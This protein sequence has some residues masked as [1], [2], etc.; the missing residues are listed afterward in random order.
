MAP[1][2]V[3]STAASTGDGATSATARHSAAL[4]DVTD[5]VEVARA[6]GPRSYASAAATYRLMVTRPGTLRPLDRS[7]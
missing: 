3:T 1:W 6:K 7:P 4:F 5:D 2:C